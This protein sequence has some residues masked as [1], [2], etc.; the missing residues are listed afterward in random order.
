[1]R[2]RTAAAAL[3]FATFAITGITATLTTGDVSPTPR[4]IVQAE[5][6]GC[7]SLMAMCAPTPPAPV[8]LTE[9]PVIVQGDDPQVRH[10]HGDGWC[11]GSYAESC[12]L[13]DVADGYARAWEEA[14][15]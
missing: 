6:V 9:P 8:G 13:T 15:R 14:K 10:E 12:D 3:V 2:T 4:V 7:P 1:M 11:R 5:P